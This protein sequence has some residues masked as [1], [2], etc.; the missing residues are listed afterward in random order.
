MKTLLVL[1][2]LSAGA[3]APAVPPPAPVLSPVEKAWEAY[4]KKDLAGAMALLEEPLRKGELGARALAGVILIDGGQGVTREFD[5]GLGLLRRAAEEGHPFAQLW[6]GNLR[7]S[8]VVPPAS[9]DEALKW[10]EKAAAGGHPVFQHE[11]ATRLLRPGPRLDRARARELLESAVSGRKFPAYPAAM[12]TLAWM[13]SDPKEGEA[14]DRPRALKL[15]HE[16]AAMGYAPHQYDLAQMYL[17]GTADLPRD[18]GQACFFLNELARN[19][20]VSQLR[21]RFCR[22]RDYLIE[23]LPPKAKQSLAAAMAEAERAPAPG[24]YPLPLR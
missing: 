24:P 16:S 21:E 6:M 3:Q 17:I 4:K 2:A 20:E 7:E 5:R 13:L 12:A 14:G 8:G 1:L 23:L 9:L 11:L 18:I 10:Y 22:E 15:M 19:P